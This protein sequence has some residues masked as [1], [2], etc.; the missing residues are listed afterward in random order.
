MTVELIIQG[1]VMKDYKNE[2]NLRSICHVVDLMTID[3]VIT[4][5]RIPEVSTAQNYHNVIKN[6]IRF[7]SLPRIHIGKKLLFP[8]QAV[9]EWV[10][11]ETIRD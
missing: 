11:K 8:K 6:L 7:R 10:E 3:E 9:L 4:F 5:L 2:H 1:Q